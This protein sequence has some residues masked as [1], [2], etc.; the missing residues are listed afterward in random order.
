MLER[1]ITVSTENR[2]TR[3]PPVFHLTTLALALSSV[4]SAQAIAADEASSSNAVQLTNININADTPENPTAPLAG[5]VA[6]RNTSATKTNAAITETPQSLSVVTADEITDRKSDTL[7]DALSYTPGFTSQPSSFNRTSDRFRIRGFDVESATGGSLRD[8][9]RLQNNSYDGVQEPFGLE[10]VEVIR[11]A[12]SVLYG[13]LSPGGFVNG[14]SKRPT[15]TPLHELGLQ[16]GNN[17]RKQLTGDFSGPLGDS[18]TL[19][20]RLTLLQRDSGTQQD[21]I[22]DDKLYIAPALTWR[23]NEDT[24]LT[25][26]AFHQKSDTRFSAPL[27]YQLVKGLGNGP[28]TIGRHD[29]IGEP[30]YDDMNGEMSAIGYEFEHNFNDNIRISNKLRYYEAE[31][32][33]KYLQ[34]PT[35]NAAAIA[36]VNSAAR[37]GLLTRQYS[38]RHERSR[39]LASDTNVEARWNIGGVENT[40]LVGADT[41]DAS[42]DSHNFRNNAPSLNLATYNYGQPVVVNKAQSAD[43]G[44]QIDT[45]QT[46][47][48]LQD[49][50]KFDDHWL[51]L[52]GG[53]HDW[54]NQDQKAFVNGQK[55]HQSDESTTWRAGL[56]Y[57][58]DNGLAPYISYSESFFPV[59][60]ADAP[61]Q[62]FAPTEGKQ[63]EMGIRYQPPGSNVLLSAAVYELTQKNVLKTVNSVSSQTGEQRSRGLELEAKADVTPQFSV[64][65]TYAY[66]DARITE[67]SVPG[68]VGQRSEDTPYHQAALWTDYNF[69]LFGIPQLKIGGGARYKGTTQASGIESQ[70]PAYFLFDAMASYQIDKNWDIAINANNVTNKKYTYCEF[71]ICRYGDERELVTSVNFRW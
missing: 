53:R 70:M 16:Y 48:Y 62:S 34:I 17:D 3:R 57:Q 43:R 50:I 38:D 21:H 45:L 58:A 39:A 56:V 54:A 67:S 52:L 51:L 28:F 7:A 42:Y 37:N 14:V 5:K 44:S 33:W 22:N 9:L 35:N 66:T 68:E 2:Y 15:E 30:G 71:A 26:L 20:Y 13:Q 69:A 25:L 49:Q 40:F 60:V 47:I 23:P 12:A 24:S 64:I 4:I 32:K 65:A 27:P 41:Y 29:F 1:K 31:M 10:R 11:G 6:L 19:S 46:G 55:R 59:A 61:T 63:Y 18:D 36:A 8:G